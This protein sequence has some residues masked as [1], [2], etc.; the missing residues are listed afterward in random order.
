MLW[1]S[2]NQA[3][4]KR[5]IP[6]VLKLADNVRRVSF[7]HLAAWSQKQHPRKANWTKPPQDWCKVSF[8]AIIRNSFSIQAAVCRNN[9]G[10]IRQILTQIRPPC[11]QVNGEALAAKLATELASSMQLNQFVLEG[12]S[13]TVI[14]A[15]HNVIPSLDST[16]DHV[17]KDILLSFSDTSL[18]EARKISRNENF[19]AHY[20]AY[21]AP[22]R[23]LP[24]CIPSLFPPPPHPSSI[25][26]CSKKDPHP[27]TPH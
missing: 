25:P 4:H 5:V 22:A 10:E 24:G 19:C 18:W 8:N 27:C 3:V 15:L 6:E 16:F 2:R 26:I 12:E 1:F 14:A 9:R 20:V 23:V 13:A 21:R 7:E 11:S 17:I